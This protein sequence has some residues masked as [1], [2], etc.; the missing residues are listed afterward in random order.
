[1]R[2]A[3][4]L[5]VSTGGTG[6]N[7][8][9]DLIVDGAA[10]F[11]VSH[12]LDF[13]LV[14][15]KSVEEASAQYEALLEFYRQYAD[16]RVLVVLASSEYEAMVRASSVPGEACRVL[17]LESAGEEMPDRVASARI[18]R[19]GAGYLVGAMVSGQ[20]AEI[21]L[22]MSGD[23]I[24]EEA[25]A[26]FEAGF[27]AHSDGQSV[28]RHYLSDGYEGFH[29]QVEARRLTTSLMDYHT[30]QEEYCTFLPLAGGSN[31]GVYNAFSGF[32]HAQQVVGMDTDCN[33]QN[34]YIPFSMLIHIDRLVQHCLTQWHDGQEMPAVDSFGL[35][36]DYVELVFSDSWDPMGIFR[37][38]DELNYD[39][40]PGDFWQSKQARYLAEAMNKENEYENR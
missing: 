5:F 39:V 6:D 23:P 32:I 28:R 21:I 40:L 24:L 12:D 18:N 22:A 7:G 10:S 19:Y 38:W 31:L 33:G 2:D 37:S 34:D 20:P 29:M 17:L 15:S 25:A 27:A 30:Q 26:G 36:S 13:Y 35:Q 14:S 16:R 3:I 11:A 8:Y 1:M 9:N 4:I